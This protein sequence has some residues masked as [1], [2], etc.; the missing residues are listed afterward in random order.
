LKAKCEEKA[1]GSVSVALL[2][3]SKTVTTEEAQKALDIIASAEISGSW[4]FT[5]TNVM[6]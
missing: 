2:E 3:N 5:I 1:D 6:K 4:E